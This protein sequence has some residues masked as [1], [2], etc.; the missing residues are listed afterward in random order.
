LKRVR[1]RACY[2]LQYRCLLHGIFHTT[3]TLRTFAHLRTRCLH[4]PP[5]HHAH[6]SHTVHTHTHTHTTPHHTHHTHAHFYLLGFCARTHTFS[7]HT[8]PH[9][10]P[11]HCHTHTPHIT[12]HAPARTHT[13]APYIFLPGRIWHAHRC[14][15]ASRCH[16][17]AHT[18]CCRT[19]T[20]HT[21]IRAWDCACARTRVLTARQLPPPSHAPRALHLPHAR[22]TP[23]SAFAPTYTT[24]HTGHHMIA[25]HT[26]THAHHTLC[27]TQISTLPATPPATHTSTLPHLGSAAAA[28]T[29][30]TGTIHTHTHTA[31][32]YPLYLLPALHHAPHTHLHTH[33]GRRT[34]PHITL[35]KV[36]VTIRMDWTWDLPHTPT[37]A[38]LR[39]INATKWADLFLPFGG[40]VVTC[41]T[42]PPP[43]TG[44][45]P[46]PCPLHREEAGGSVD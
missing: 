29:H 2:W 37:W 19:H 31:S 10:V 30:F 12:Y 20:A 5:P 41:W 15:R 45:S 13:C 24:P 38:S 17:H 39:S 35:H 28:H 23:D 36:L 22:A 44:S 8:S 1:I 18:P 32:H 7:A 25:H 11:P 40:Q 43:L 16:L 6:L 14:L 9:T 3:H 33:T 46:A 26:R 34:A 42:P 4:L 27:P 21:R